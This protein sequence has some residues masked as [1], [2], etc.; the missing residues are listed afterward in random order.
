MPSSVPRRSY[1][2]HLLLLLS[3][4]AGCRSER[5]AFNFQSVPGGAAPQQAVTASAEA[6]LPPVLRPVLTSKKP[7]RKRHAG[8]Y[9]TLRPPSGFIALKRTAPSQLRRLPRQSPPRP[10]YRSPQ[11]TDAAWMMFFVI[12]LAAGVVLLSLLAWGIGALL[13]F[14]FWQSMRVVAL[15]LAFLLV[16][17]LISD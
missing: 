5:V 4:L 9:T 10:G 1:A 12:V 11:D 14:T 6:S 17:F 13:G 8:L 15:L 7:P 2:W 3:V 16:L